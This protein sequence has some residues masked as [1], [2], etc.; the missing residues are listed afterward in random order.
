MAVGSKDN[1]FKVFSLKQLATP[2]KDY[3]YILTQI[4]QQHP[5]ALCIDPS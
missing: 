1:Q 4:P 5:T 2:V 3:L